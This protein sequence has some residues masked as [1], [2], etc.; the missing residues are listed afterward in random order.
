MALAGN[1]GQSVRPQAFREWGHGHDPIKPSIAQGQAARTWP[2]VKTSWRLV[3]VNLVLPGAGLVVAG[4]LLPGLL[5]LVPTVILIALILGVLALFI[6]SAAWPIAASLFSL[7]IALSVIAGSWWWWQ[8]RRGRIDPTKVRA[9]HR[10]A[11]IAYLQGRNAEAV[12]TARE[13]VA[14]APQES[15]AWHFLALVATAANDP[16]LARRA[17][18]KGRAIDER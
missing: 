11:A 9:L 18:A 6:S 2:T 14:A 4:H 16:A 12:T 5:L 7:Y 3:M 17:T 8:S 13:L 1:L 10:T 15:G